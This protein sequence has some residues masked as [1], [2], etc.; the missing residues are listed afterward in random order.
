LTDGNAEVF[1]CSI[2]V[3][4]ALLFYQI[5]FLVVGTR[6]LPAVLS[7][8]EFVS[9]LEASYFLAEVH[10]P[11]RERLHL[12]IVEHDLW[13]AARWALKL[14]LFVLF[15]DPALMELGGAVL[16]A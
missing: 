7:D 8:S 13:A 11:V 2:D 16:H 3:V 15:D 5:A 12:L 14:F 10:V 4:H 1:V 6:D 9:A